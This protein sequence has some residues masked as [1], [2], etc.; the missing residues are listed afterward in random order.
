MKYNGQPV[1]GV[2]RR[3]YPDGSRM[4]ESPYKDG[5]LHG[6]DTFWRPDGQKRVE[7]TLKDGKRH[8]LSTWWYENGQK[9]REYTFK[10]GEVISRKRWDKDG[11][12]FYPPNPLI[13]PGSSNN[14]QNNMIL[15][16]TYRN[17]LSGKSIST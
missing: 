16:D 11:N 8:G 4:S 13:R 9:S 1:T 2:I 17:S 3:T 15:A 6:L 12:P 10:D 14:P 7:Y 5:E